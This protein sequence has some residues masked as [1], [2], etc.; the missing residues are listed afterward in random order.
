MKILV[1]TGMFPPIRT[2]TSFYSK[3]LVDN[4][5]KHGHQV[6]LVTV[7]NSDTEEGS[8]PYQ[9]VR[10]PALHFPMKSYF[11]HL[12]FCSLFPCNYISI[13]RL[14]KETQAEVI[15]LV[16]HYLDIA[17]PAIYA[18][19]RHKIPLIV[20]VGT[21]LQSLNPVRNKIL[22]ILDRIICGG[23]IYPFCRKIVSWD[24]E[25]ERYIYDIQSKST[26]Q[27]SVIVPFGVN[28]D[29]S[30]YKKHEHNYELHNQ[31]LGVGAVI[32]HRN[33]L[34]QVQVFSRLLKY[35]P[36]LRLKIIGHQ[37][38]SAPVQLVK[39]LG[40]NNQVEFTGELPHSQV[41]EELRK[42]DIHWMMLTSKYKGLGTSTLE[43]MLMG[44]P[45][46]SNVPEGLLG[47]DQLKNFSNYIYT[48]GVSIDETVLNVKKI[49]ENRHLR[50]T[51]GQNGKHLV[52]ENMNW[53]KVVKRM[54]EVIQGVLR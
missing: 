28:G 3:N 33:F 41:L 17:F 12:R 31:I 49:L 45:C 51:I 7:V 54:E 40:I 24:K 13:S 6:T 30:E 37:Y 46:F 10:I 52:Q 1:V 47:I 43:A 23:A 11:K 16:N 19:I 4:M 25:I 42:S 44:V 15:L 35:Y 27:K 38:I 29:I 5:V 34:F 2:G 20:S 8:Y 26:S 22:N 14:V 18:S 53:D 21:Q 32:D 9:V 36:S 48:D 39:E 50:V